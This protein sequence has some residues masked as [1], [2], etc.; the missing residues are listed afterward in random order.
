MKIY[1][2]DDEI[3][4]H[5]QI[6]RKLNLYQRKSNMQTTIERKKKKRA[7]IQRKRGDT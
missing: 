7:K 3:R 6:K 4:D 1:Y 5:N 2:Q